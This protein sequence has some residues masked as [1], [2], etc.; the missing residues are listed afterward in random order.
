[1][2][3]GR[4]QLAGI[5]LLL[6]LAAGVLAGCGSGGGSGSPLTKAEYVAQGNKI[7]AR[8]TKKVEAEIEEYAGEHNLRY[9][10][11]TKKDYEKE[12]E[13]VFVP[14]VERKIDQLQELEPPAKDEQEIAKML[15]AAEKGLQ[16][17]QSEP[18]TL[19]SGQ[20][21]AE[22]RKLATEY[23]LKECF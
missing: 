21:L 22:A 20:A 12:A 2:F 14:V 7:C 5:G 15:A 9:R 18:F 8:E 1:M 10:E 17:G 3:F 4:R 13:E 11:P 23:G 6:L 16:E 19:I